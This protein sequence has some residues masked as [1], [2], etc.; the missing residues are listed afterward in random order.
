[1]WAA[2][3]PTR[4]RLVGNH[5]DSPGQRDGGSRPSATLRA[6]DWFGRRSACFATRSPCQPSK[7]FASGTDVHFSSTPGRTKARAQPLSTGFPETLGDTDGRRFLG[8]V[9]CRVP[10][11]RA[12][13]AK[14]FALCAIGGASSHRLRKC[15]ANWHR[16]C[17]HI[18]RGEFSAGHD[19]AKWLGAGSSEECYSCLAV[20]VRLVA[21]P[22]P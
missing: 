14:T 18:S 19:A 5:V 11:A 20:F 22:A 15:F 13:D 3:R 8:Q 2:D 21:R 6:D 16:L 17:E 12:H 9:R 7:V 1:M 4:P 10:V